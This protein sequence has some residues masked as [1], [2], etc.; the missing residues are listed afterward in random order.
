MPWVGCLTSDELDRDHVGAL[1]QHLEVRMLAVGA[2]LAPDHRAGRERQRVAV[3]VDRLPLD[4]ISS[5]CR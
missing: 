2:G 3:D 1:V 4:S 5:C